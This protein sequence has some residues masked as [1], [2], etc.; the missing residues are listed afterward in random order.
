M[1]VFQE[2]I[3]NILTIS[4]DKALLLWLIILSIIFFMNY[5]K[6]KKE[7]D[8][9][10]EE[11][12]SG[13]MAKYPNLYIGATPRIGGHNV[14]DARCLNEVKAVDELLFRH[15]PIVL[16]MIATGDFAASSFINQA[17]QSNPDIWAAFRCI[18]QPNS[19]DAKHNYVALDEKSGMNMFKSSTKGTLGYITYDSKGIHSFTKE[20][21]LLREYN[22]KRLRQLKQAFESDSLLDVYE[23]RVED[24]LNEFGKINEADISKLCFLQERVQDFL[25]NDVQ[26][27]PAFRRSL[28]MVFTQRVDYEPASARLNDFCERLLFHLKNSGRRNDS[29]NDD[30]FYDMNVVG[31]KKVFF[32]CSVRAYE[33]VIDPSIRSK[34][35]H[36]SEGLKIIFDADFIEAVKQL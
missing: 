25:V 19:I 16:W 12:Y 6:A 26:T 23:H 30:R 15:S 22:I 32:Y 2:I 17:Q 29:Y 31:H 34:M 9:P 4:F 33:E 13:V 11:F 10:L 20:E 5:V 18:S 1:S 3:S 14:T 7:Q 28:S 36:L 8:F 21:I 35:K 27:N 24:F